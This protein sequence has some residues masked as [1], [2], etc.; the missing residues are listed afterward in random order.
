MSYKVV[1]FANVVDAV[2][3]AT[4]VRVWRTGFCWLLH[5]MYVYTSHAVMLLG[6]MFSHCK[7]QPR[8][9]ILRSHGM[10]LRICDC[11]SSLLLLMVSV[12]HWWFF[13]RRMSHQ[14]NQQLQGF[15]CTLDLR[16][17]W[18]TSITWDQ[19]L[20]GTWL[21]EPSCLH[22]IVKRFRYVCKDYFVYLRFWL[23]DCVSRAYSYHLRWSFQS[24][25]NGKG[26]C[27]SKLRVLV[28][29]RRSSVWNW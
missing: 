3:G 27:W 11:V 7:I 12:W 4:R 25:C 24:N 9:K 15:W 5:S 16:T 2:S 29:V 23:P 17:D 20:S 22:V 13:F 6:S 10:A 19:L 26:S 21:G 8:P 28:P 18:R 14:I 1:I